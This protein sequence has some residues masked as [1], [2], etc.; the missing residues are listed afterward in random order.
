VTTPP[1]RLPRPLKGKGEVIGMVHLL[2]SEGGE[3]E[4]QVCLVS[5]EHG[6]PTE[7]E[8][9]VL[10]LLSDEALVVDVT[11]GLASCTDRWKVTRQDVAGVPLQ[12]CDYTRLTGSA[13]IRI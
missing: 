2:H 3:E 10:L 4:A 7:A 1:S 5:T 6:Y 9:I 8:A 13:W 12:G 11:S